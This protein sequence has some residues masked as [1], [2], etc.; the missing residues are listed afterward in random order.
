MEIAAIGDV[1]WYRG[2]WAGMEL[3][4][5]NKLFHQENE[6]RG[7]EK[8]G[9]E[10]TKRLPGAGKASETRKDSG[11]RSAAGKNDT[12]KAKYPGWNRRNG[13]WGNTYFC[14]KAG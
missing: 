4:S 1:I 2:Q 5:G 10:G 12:A 3:E 6:R 7:H 13:L 9:R 11:A 14:K 8:N